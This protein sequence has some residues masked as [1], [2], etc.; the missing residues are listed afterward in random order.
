MTEAPR[1]NVQWHAEDAE[2]TREMLVAFASIIQSFA[3]LEFVL[4]LTM[5]AVGRIGLD[6]AMPLT[7]GLG[8]QGKRDALFAISEGANVP[9]HQLDEIRSFLD[10]ADRFNALRNAIAHSVWVPGTRP[11]SIKPMGIKVR[12]KLKYVGV[13]D[14]ERDYT[15]ADLLGAADKL[16]IINNSYMDFLRQSGLLSHIEEK[17]A[18]IMSRTNS[19]NHV[20]DEFRSR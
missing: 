3:R 5:A 1:G 9:Q 14:S 10:E 13:L 4:Q 19:A 17:M 20:A 11:N 16:V 12:G 15:Q 18:A 2:L 7:A 8:Y 6:A